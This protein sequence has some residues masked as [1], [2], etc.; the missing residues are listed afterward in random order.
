MQLSPCRI[1]EEKRVK[2]FNWLF[3][4]SILLK[5]KLQKIKHWYTESAYFT[6]T[7]IIVPWLA[8]DSLYISTVLIFICRSAIYSCFISISQTK[9]SGRMLFGLTLTVT[10]TVSLTLKNQIC[11]PV[12]WVQHSSWSWIQSNSEFSSDLEM[13]PSTAGGS[14]SKRKKEKKYD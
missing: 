9:Y 10:L 13:R 14:N 2:L 5:N 7:V 6:R 12:C 1:T 11:K 4:N 8:W 3:S